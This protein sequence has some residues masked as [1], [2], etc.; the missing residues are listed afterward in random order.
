MC[1]TLSRASD[2]TVMNHTG[3]LPNLASKA[4]LSAGFVNR[5]ATPM[6]AR[7]TGC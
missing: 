4:A 6:A 7:L 1:S 5:F 3:A 2:D